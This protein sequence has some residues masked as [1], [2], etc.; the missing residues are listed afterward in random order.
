MSGG[1]KK[2]RHRWR[3]WLLLLIC[4]AVI[5][6]IAVT[7][8]Q[9]WLLQSHNPTTTSWMRMRVRQANEKGVKLEIR[10]TW[11]PLKRIPNVLVSAILAAED[12]GF[13]QHH[14]FDWSA[15]KEAYHHNEAKGKIKRGGSTITQ[16]L[17]KNLY[18]SPKRNYVRKA[19]EGFIT[20]VMELLLSKDRILELYLNCIEMGP[21]VFG[22]EEG[23]KFQFGVSAANLSLDQAC[24]LAA[25]IPSPLKYKINGKFITNRAEII[26][27]R[28]KE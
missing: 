22:V 28:I 8:L 14:G 10:R 16:Q 25:I 5:L 21:G 3:K 2:G 6:P 23:A 15:I 4:A 13:Y 9:V 26:A 1:R 11:L 27:G 12:D 17:A 19:R 20:W 7:F 18:L 24:R